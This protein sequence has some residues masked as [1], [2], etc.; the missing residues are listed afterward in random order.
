MDVV[1]HRIKQFERKIQDF[2]G[3]TNKI[4]KIFAETRRGE[5]RRRKL[6]IAVGPVVSAMNLGTNYGVSKG[7]SAMF[8]ASLFFPEHSLQ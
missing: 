3:E 5:G 6:R 2:Q 8:L 4:L 1:N 7:K